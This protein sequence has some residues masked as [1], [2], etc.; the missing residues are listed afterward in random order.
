MRKQFGISLWG[1]IATLALLGFVG[2][3]AAKLL[4]YYLEYFAV[5]KIIAAM[6][7]AGEMKGTVR[8]IRY[9]FDKRNAIEDVKSM[10]GD[11]LEVTKEGAETVV[12]VSWSARVP[13]VYNVNACLD[14]YVTTAK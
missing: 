4:P 8:E 1:L 12:S 9:T 5:K 11:D 7:A 6:E 13:M 3:M 10:K 14:F 2:V